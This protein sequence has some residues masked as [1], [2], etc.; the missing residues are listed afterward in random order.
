MSFKTKT[1]EL[2]ECIGNSTAIQKGDVLFGGIYSILNDNPVTKAKS[3]PPYFVRQSL[4][5]CSNNI[6]CISTDKSMY[7]LKNAIPFGGIFS[8]CNSVPLQTSCPDGLKMNLINIIDGC[9]IYYCAKFKNLAQPAL[10]KLPFVPKPPSY[11]LI[12]S[13]NKSRK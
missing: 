11:N 10:K 13:L 5:D 2:T 12:K 3:C 9:M 7:A 6:I 4:F 8:S 1:I